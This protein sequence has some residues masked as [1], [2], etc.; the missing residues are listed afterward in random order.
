MKDYIIE[1]TFLY[2]EDYDCLPIR[3]KVPME[4]TLKEV[5]NALCEAHNILDKNEDESKQGSK[6]CLEDSIAIV[7]IFTTAVC[8]DFIRYIPIRPKCTRSQYELLRWL[9][10]LSY[11]LHLLI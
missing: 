10:I 8:L 7:I 2:D 3:L 1:I 9:R 6:L 11:S 4:T 5:K